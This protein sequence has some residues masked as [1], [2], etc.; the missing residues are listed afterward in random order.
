M[1]IVHYMSKMVLES[2]GPIRAIM[3]L[4]AALAKAGHEVT[5]LTA[6]AEDIPA[7]WK[8][9]TDPR[10][11]KVAILPPLKRPFH[12]IDKAG[13]RQA[14]EVLRQ[15]DI[16]H[17]HGVWEPSNVQIYKA[18]KRVGILHAVSLRGMLD[19]W[20][21]SQRRPKKVLFLRLYGYELLNSAA[22][23]HCTAYGELAQSRKWFHKSRAVVIPNFMDMAPFE[24]L[25]GPAMAKKQWPQLD[26][27][28]PNVLFLSRVNYKKGVEIYIDMAKM[29]VDRGSDA[30]FIIA[31]KGEDPAYVQRMKD[32][33]NSL[34]LH[35]RVHF[36]GLVKPPMRESLYQ[37]S[38]LLV[39]P[40]SQENFGFVFYESL[41]CAVPIVTTYFVDTWPELKGGASAEICEPRPEEFADVAE[42]LLADRAALRVTGLKGQEWVREAMAY[43]RVFTQFVRA[44]EA[45]MSRA[46]RRVQGPMDPQPAQ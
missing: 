26:H 8:A 16:A 19:D 1:R 18:A 9:G 27:A 17:L 4:T 3:D 31:G 28:G 5:I 40:T 12:L 7:S 21:M 24:N 45:A 15:H 43:D 13:I 33:V 42:R 36:L 35:S 6:D 44:Y 22:F 30:Q 10:L 29:L 34:G 38:E 11:P 25:P 23:I 2:G 14:E 39:I 41:A 37:A 46:G 32:R 20:P